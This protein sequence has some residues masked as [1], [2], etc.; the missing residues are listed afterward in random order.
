MDTRPIWPSELFLDL[1]RTGPIPLYFQ[2]ASRL[3]AAIRSGAIPSGARLEN[4][5]AIA[6][7]LGM[8]RPTIRRAIQD[9][10]DKG[11]LVRRRGIGTQV[12]QGQVTRQVELTSLYEDLKVAH[13]EPGTRL[14]LHEVIPAPEKIAEHLALPVGA[15]VVHLRRQ[16][17][18]D[19]VAVAVLENFLPAQFA[20]ALADHLEERGLYQM[21]R[22]SGVTISV[23]KQSI[24][25]RRAAADESDLLGIDKGGPVL[26]ME[27]IAYDNSGRA[28]EYGRHCYR[29]DLYSF[30]TTLVAK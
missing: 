14:L 21:L 16:R 26:T 1:D 30:E 10:V 3:E 25:A 12:V 8:S 5:I 2:V 11:L 17:S 27:R 19:G 7:S 22:G 18:T 28:I 24:G 15:E 23:A 4:E 13:H 29:P 6:Q 20:T 9:L